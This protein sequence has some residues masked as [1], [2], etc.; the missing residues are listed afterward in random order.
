VATWGGL[1]Y[2]ALAES[3]I[4]LSKTE[5]I[6]WCGPWRDL[7]AV[8]FAALKW[9]HWF[10]HRRLLEPIGYIGSCLMGDRFEPVCLPYS[11]RMATLSQA[12]ADLIWTLSFEPMAALLTY[13]ASVQAPI[14][15]QRRTGNTSPESSSALW[16]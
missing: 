3:I 5:V 12:L 2:N 7:E 6:R 8:E 11:H 10:N 16:A 15:D 13:P 4:G 14:I 1:V 9:L